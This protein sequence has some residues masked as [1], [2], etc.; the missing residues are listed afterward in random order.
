MTQVVLRDLCILAYGNGITQW[1]YRAP[2]SHHPG[3]LS[4]PAY[5]A[6]AVNIL[7]VGDWL[8]TTHTLPDGRVHSVLYAFTSGPLGLWAQQLLSSSPPIGQQA[9]YDGDLNV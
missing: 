7:H 5:W 8:F 3:L 1:G 2:P 4:D 6:D 9:T